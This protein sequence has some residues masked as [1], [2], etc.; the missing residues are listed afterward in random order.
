LLVHVSSGRACRCARPKEK[1]R[2]PFRAIP[3]CLAVW[4]ALF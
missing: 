2:Q 3:N 1:M 4:S